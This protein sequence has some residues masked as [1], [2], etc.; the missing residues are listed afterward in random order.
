MIALEFIYKKINQW[1]MLAGCM[2][3]FALF[4]PQGALGAL[5]IV[6]FLLSI[7]FVFYHSLVLFKSLP[8]VVLRRDLLI[9]FFIVLGG[10]LFD[11]IVTVYCSPNLSEEGNPIFLTLV[12]LNVPLW[13][14]YLILFFSQVFMVGFTLILWASFLKVYPRI[15]STIPYK[16]LFT[17]CKWLLG[18]GQMSFLDFILNRKLNYCFFISFCTFL[19]VLCH[20]NRWYFAME[21]L[22]LVPF[23]R[24]IPAITICITLVFF[25]IKTH[26]KIKA[27]NFLKV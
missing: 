21:W 1:F 7:F 4:R 18:C 19:M 15:I 9:G 10:A 14:I 20:L 8:G 24:T 2:A 22:E 3:L 25:L 12:D 26:K 5:C 17:T 27:L 16:N 6:V 23:S 13:G 11:I